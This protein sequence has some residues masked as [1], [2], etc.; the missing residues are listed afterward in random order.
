MTSPATSY[1]PPPLS[2]YGQA[3]FVVDALD[4]QAARDLGLLR[5]DVVL[6]SE[7]S[8]AENY[9]LRRLQYIFLQTT[10]L[11]MH[12]TC[13]TMIALDACHSTISVMAPLNKRGKHTR[14]FQRNLDGSF[15]R[16]RV[17]QNLANRPP[18]EEIP[19]FRPQSG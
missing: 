7:N 14:N 9:G 12:Y 3:R 18:P 8:V 10:L 2:K 16:L 13:S 17:H 6:D 5:D 11:L 15:Y 1:E 19:A 4:V